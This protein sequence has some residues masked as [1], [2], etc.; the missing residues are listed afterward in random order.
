MM[1][2]L[3]LI[4]TIIICLILL[5]LLKKDIQSI[6]K[7][8]QYKN[9]TNSQIEI[10]STHSFKEIQQLKE[11]INHLYEN[12]LKLREKTINKEKEMQT[13]I[14]GMSHDMRTPLTS[15]QGYLDLLKEA[16]SEEERKKYTEIIEYRLSSLKTMLED[17]F[18]H[19][20]LND[21]QFAIE[22]QAISLYP[23]LC[24]V[25][26]SFYPDFCDQQIE[27]QVSFENEKLQA[28]G[29]EELFSRIVQNLISNA[30]NHGTKSFEIHQ[31]ENQ[32]IFSNQIRNKEIDINKLFDRFYK[33]DPSRHHISSGLG[34]SNV[35]E[36]ANT[37]GWSVSAS[38]DKDQ[39][40]II[41]NLDGNKES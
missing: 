22:L 18:T 21:S 37:M 20:K 2:N 33:A 41:L 34:L 3:I 11:E 8:I 6:N 40:S 29:N 38:L 28:N 12:N 39:L 23:I 9:Q 14:S 7:Q 10:T 4:G 26:A 30:L 17:L 32:I 19:A 25:L 16:Q 36:M 1:M 24:K 15:L 35:K 31:K 27:P 5:F 13:L